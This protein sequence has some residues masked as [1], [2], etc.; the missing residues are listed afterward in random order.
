MDTSLNDLFTL[1]V[2][3]FEPEIQLISSG[4]QYDWDTVGG[5]EFT[6]ESIFFAASGAQNFHSMQYMSNWEDD[7]SMTQSAGRTVIGPAR[8]GRWWHLDY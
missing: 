8:T 4:F 5:K 7:G 6:N 3:G 2:N 1:P